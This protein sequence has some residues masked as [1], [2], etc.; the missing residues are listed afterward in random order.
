MSEPERFYVRSKPTIIEGFR[1]LRA[2]IEKIVEARGETLDPAWYD[3]GLE[4]HPEL[5]KDQL[6]LLK[7]T[8][9]EGEST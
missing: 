7:P 1:A 5:Y 4:R 3:D 6:E 8:P 2:A 9:N